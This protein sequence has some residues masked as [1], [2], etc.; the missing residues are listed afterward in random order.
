MEGITLI[1]SPLVTFAAAADADSDS[2][3]LHRLKFSWVR[4]ERYDKA[5]GLES[6]HNSMLTAT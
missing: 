6:K 1:L 5:K 3:Q 4:W 2:I